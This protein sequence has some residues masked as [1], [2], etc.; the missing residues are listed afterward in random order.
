MKCAVECERL[1]DFPHDIR[2]VARNTDPVSRARAC[3]TLM[4][5]ILNM[6]I[7]SDTV[8]FDIALF[9]KLKEEVESLSFDLSGSRNWGFKEV[10]GDLP[11]VCE[12]MCSLD[13]PSFD[14]WDSHLRAIFVQCVVSKFS[15][16]TGLTYLVV[17]AGDQGNVGHYAGHP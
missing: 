16:F 4:L 10:R 12:S 17:I 2:T 1:E 8:L 6:N 13:W 5:D 11:K 15:D 14:R 3:V 9:W 7:D